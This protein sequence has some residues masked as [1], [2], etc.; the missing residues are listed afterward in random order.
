MED[1]RRREIALF[2]YALVR[3][4]A[5]PQ[6]TPRERGALVRDLAGRQHLGPDGQL[7]EVGRS[8]IDKWIT[9]YRQHGF[10]G[11]VPTLRPTGPVTDPVVLELAVR[12]KEEQPQRTA[13]QIRDII[14]ASTGEAPSERTIQRHFVR[15]GHRY[16][17]DGRPPKSFGRFEAEQVN[18]LWVGDALH[19]PVVGKG[20]AILFAFLDDHSRL[21]TGYRWGRAEDSVRLEA[22]LRRG[23][24]ARGLPRRIYVDNGAPFIAGPLQRACAV[25]GIRLIHSRP[26]EPAG[27]GKIE[28]FFHTVRSQFLVEIPTRGVADTE[29]LNTLFIAWVEQVYHRRIHTETQ[30]T[31]LERFA[32]AGV[33]DLPI[34][35]LLR[36]AFLWSETRTV[37]K[38][39]L[40]ALHGNRYETDP[41]LVGR[42]VQV[43]FDPFDLTQVEIRFNGQTFGTAGIHTLGAHVHPKAVNAVANPDDMPAAHSGIDYLAL[44]AAEHDAATRRAINFA[45]LTGDADDQD[46]G[47]AA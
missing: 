29:E 24:A 23:L 22:A 18:D 2:R 45:D 46:A 13:A 31:P 42:K 9:A 39:G 28:R 16:R 21:L 35:A 44:V 6:L 17:P 1:P 33:T 27:R 47:D 40:V 10:D 32:A 41:A 20:K 8:T 26:G 19:G 5:D 34:P 3:Q 25:L 4:A 12:L 36:E 7:V 38:T 15:T 14:W 11:L 43:I 30:Q 37:T